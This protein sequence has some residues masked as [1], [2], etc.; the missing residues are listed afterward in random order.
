MVPSEVLVHRIGDMTLFSVGQIKGT[1]DEEV[2]FNPNWHEL[3]KQ[4]K[5]SS[6]APPRSKFYKTQ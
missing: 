6:L 1:R 2:E 5:C 3:R 4:E